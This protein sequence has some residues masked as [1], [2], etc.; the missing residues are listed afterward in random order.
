MSKYP[1]LIVLRH[2]ETE[3][4]L[5]N[6]MQG[7]LNSP[8]T[9]R[10]IAHAQ[11]QC[12]LLSEFDLSDWDVFCSPQG[13]AVQTAGLAAG[14]LVTTITTDPLL[15]EIGVGE[16]QGKL[17]DTLKYDGIRQDGPDGPI[18]LYEHA[19]GGEGFDRLEA[20]CHRFL[21]KLE[22]PSV[23]ITHGITSRMLRVLVL[24]L[25]RSE[26]GKIAG[27][28]GNLFHLKDGMQKELV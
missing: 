9:S 19:P 21:S 10:G 18:N 17:R 8:L 2:G 11:R 23:L 14:P 4:N 1:E 26:I 22:R 25:D 28:Q 6:R 27:G 15:R 12:E 24:G 7:A 13:R 3:W 5:E 20:R 16:W